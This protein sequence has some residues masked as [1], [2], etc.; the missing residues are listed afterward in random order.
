[1]EA[2]F[3]AT[4]SIRPVQEQHVQVGVQVQGRAKTLDQSDRSRPGTASHGEPGPTNQESRNSTLHHRQ[5]FGECSGFR[6]Q[7][8]PAAPEVFL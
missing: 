1:M 7:P 5:H 4:E 2:R 3:T 8:K 6:G